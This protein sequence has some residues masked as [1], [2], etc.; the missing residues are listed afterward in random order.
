MK[1]HEMVDGVQSKVDLV[2]FIEALACDLREHPESWEN[3]S[4]D[5][6]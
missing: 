3:N 1:I 2:N 4:L 6:F 5:R